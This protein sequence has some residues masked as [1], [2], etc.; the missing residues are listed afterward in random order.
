MMMLISVGMK[1]T[2]KQEQQEHLIT[3]RDKKEITITKIRTGGLQFWKK[4]N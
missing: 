1:T 2:E 3:A 4:A